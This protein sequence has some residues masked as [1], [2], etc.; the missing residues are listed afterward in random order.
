MHAWPIIHYMQNYVH[1]NI[2]HVLNYEE[3]TLHD[4]ASMWHAMTAMH[5]Y[6]CIQGCLSHRD[7][8]YKLRVYMHEIR[9][10]CAATNLT[11]HIQLALQTCVLSC[12]HAGKH[13]CIGACL[14]GIRVFYITVSELI[15]SVLTVSELS[16]TGAMMVGKQT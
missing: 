4:I 6:T 9:A 5:A 1:H 10:V 15:C 8:S 7:K 16:E 13:L 11:T 3:L 14:C 12:I 2:M